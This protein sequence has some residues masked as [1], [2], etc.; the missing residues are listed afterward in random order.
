LRHHTKKI[1][2]LVLGSAALICLALL[3]KKDSPHIWADLIL[4]HLYL[5]IAYLLRFHVLKW[6]QPKK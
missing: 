2:F 4:W 1:L 6:L 5:L 3:I